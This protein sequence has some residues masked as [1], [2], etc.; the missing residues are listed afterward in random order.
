MK[1]ITIFVTI[2]I[3]MGMFGYAATYIY[4]DRIVTP[5]QSISDHLN[6]SGDINIGYD[7]VVGDDLTVTDDSEFNGAMLIDSPSG[8]L[9]LK[10]DGGTYAGRI[11]FY[12]ETN[13]K[14]WDIRVTESGEEFRWYNKSGD[15]AVKILQNGSMFFKSHADFTS[16]PNPQG[17]KLDKLKDFKVMTDTCKNGKCDIDK[18]TLPEECLV[19]DDEMGVGRDLTCYTSWQTLAMQDLLDKIEENEDE[20][21]ELRLLIEQLQI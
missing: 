19:N 17:S 8:G 11:Q 9:I 6:V 2:V 3:L 7:L 4:P 18:S 20:I 1:R 5:M 13:T 16:S 15:V 12:N 14:L 10:N 21:K